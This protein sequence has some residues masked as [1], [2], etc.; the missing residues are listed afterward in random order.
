M[1]ESREYRGLRIV[2]GQA[3]RY[4]FFLTHNF[5]YGS[6]TKIEPLLNLEL[7]RFKFGRGLFA[8]T[9]RCLAENGARQGRK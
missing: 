8:L 5:F 4:N 9:S 6:L 2:A 7:N 1:Q 3:V